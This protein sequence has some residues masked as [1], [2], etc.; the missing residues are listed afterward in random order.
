LHWSAIYTRSRNERKVD[1]RLTAI[2]IR[3]Y[4]PTQTTLRQWS[5][6]KKKVT[7]AVFKSYVFV[8]YKSEEERM[9]VLQTAGVVNYVKYLGKI[10][11][12]PEREIAV[13]R[14]FLEG[15]EK[16][17]VVD[18]V[19]GDEVEIYAGALKGKKG[20]VEHTDGATVTLFIEALGMHLHAKVK[21]QYLTKL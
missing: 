7:E 21:A 18:I 4:C 9:Q 12:I 3:V 20:I 2:G 17:E 5:D 13:I 1:E 8:Q 14:N 19:S 10:A 15:T 16:V 11:Q 6:R